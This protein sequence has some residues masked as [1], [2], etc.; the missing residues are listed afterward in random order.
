MGV[1]IK[2]NPTHAVL[3]F[4]L[5]CINP[6]MDG[7]IHRYKWLLLYQVNDVW[8]FAAVNLF[9]FICHLVTHVHCPS[10]ACSCHL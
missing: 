10:P 8:G 1:T 2:A 9:A 5:M 4:V 3:R 6:Y 7:Y